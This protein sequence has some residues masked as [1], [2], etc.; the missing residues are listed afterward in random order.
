MALLLSGVSGRG[1]L[2]QVV[3][4]E[5]KQVVERLHGVGSGC[6]YDVAY[7]VAPAGP[8]SELVA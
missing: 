3:P 2:E 8:M 1:V 7:R 4:C 5:S 6:R